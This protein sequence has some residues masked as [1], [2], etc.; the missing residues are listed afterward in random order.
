MQLDMAFEKK[1]AGAEKAGRNQ[2]LPTRRLW[3]HRWLS[4]WLW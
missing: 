3:P 4:E 2:H 1:S